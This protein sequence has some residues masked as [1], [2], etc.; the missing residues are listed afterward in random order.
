[1]TQTVQAILDRPASMW[2]L[3]QSIILD[4]YDGPREAF[5]KMNVPEAVE[6]YLSLL[7]ERV[8]PNDLDERIF[9]AHIIPDGTFDKLMNEL[10]FL[11]TPT[12]NIWV[13]I[14]ENS[15]PIALENARKR[16]IAAKTSGKFD[17]LLVASKDL[18][19]IIGVWIVKEIGKGKI[20]W[21]DRLNI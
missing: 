19:R 17:G 13:P 4:W 6:L 11:G 20:N 9:M 7:D 2:S 15:D 10:K 3:D 1:M 16:I 12:T 21:F 18:K 5:V 14:W 8:S